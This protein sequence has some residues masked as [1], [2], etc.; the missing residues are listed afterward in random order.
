MTTQADTGPILFHSSVE[1][2]ALFYILAA[3][4]VVGPAVVV[5]F[6]V[7][8]VWGQSRQTAYIIAAAATVDFLA[9]WFVALIIRWMEVT[10][11]GR[12]VRIGSRVF[13]TSVP[14]EDILTAEAVRPAGA[15]SASAQRGYREYIKLTTRTGVYNVP[16]VNA[17][18]LVEL[19]HEYGGIA[20]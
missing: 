4:A 1:R 15:G 5:G 11:D 6:A 18:A 13:K 19:L 8:F 17:E 14:L 7:P 20:T 9:T 10:F 2:K 12:Q 16:C 3:A